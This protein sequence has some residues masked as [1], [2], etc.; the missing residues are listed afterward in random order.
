MKPGSKEDL[1][2]IAELIAKKTA[3]LVERTIGLSLPISYITIFTHAQYEYERFIEWAQELG[4][5]AEANNGLK[6]QLNEPLQTA[7]GT[8][9]HIRIRKPDVYRCQLGCADFKVEDYVTF[10]EEE[11]PKHPE[12]LRLIERP[13]YEMLEFF[14]FDTNHVL[15]YIVSE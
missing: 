12:N 10:K 1:I 3:S 15:A 11:L 6:F 4:Q 14:D 13:E 9:T 5:S 7:N 2:K 8:V